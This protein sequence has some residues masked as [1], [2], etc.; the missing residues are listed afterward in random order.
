MKPI[1]RLLVANR[2]EIACRV[3][4]T[5][6][7]L[8]IETVA[9]YADADRHAPHAKMADQ[10]LRIGPSPVTESYLAIDRILDAARQTRSDAIHPGYGLLSENAAFARR[11]DETGIVFVGPSASAIELMG[12]KARAKRA[13]IDAG[14]PCVPG[15]QDEDQ[16]PETLLREARRIGFPLMV[17][18]VAGG[19]GRGMRLVR[20]LAG[21]EAA[22]AS[23]RSEAINAFGAGELILEKAIVRPRHVEVQV[24]GDRHGTVLYLGERDCSV[25]R[26]HQ[27]VIE[28]APCPV[29]T[30]ELRARMGAAA[31]SAARAVRYV[32]AGTVEFLLAEDGS[33]HFL[34]MNTR[35]QVEHPVTEEI[36]GLDLV[37]LQ[38]RVAAGE[39]LGFRQEDVRLTGHAIEVRLYAED[40][41]SGFVPSTGPI[42]AWR[43]PGG[44]GIRVDSGIETGGEVSPFYDSMLAKVIARGNSR[45]DALRRLVRSLSASMLVG[46]ATNRDFLIEALQR[47]SFARGDATTAFVEE[48]FGDEG[49]DPAPTREDLCMAAVAQYRLRTLTA[50]SQSLG[51]N[52]ELLN[53]S[54]N[55]RLEGVSVYL[56]GEDPKTFVV[57][58]EASDRYRVS[59]GDEFETA[60]RVP[61]FDERHATFEGAGGRETIAMHAFGDGRT[62]ALATRSLEFT[63][64][65]VVARDLSGETAGSGTILSPMHG[66]V[67]DVFVKEGDKVSRGQRIAL[68]EAM[69]M[70]H[71]ITADVDGTV[72]AVQVTPKEQ[73]EMNAP[74]VEIEARD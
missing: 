35:L 13:M 38:L 48:E 9:V 71:E 70:Q 72:I 58:P 10:A 37:E 8:G 3:M 21:M 54:S 24:F 32:G 29:M 5:A 12:D 41:R 36:T 74:I 22:I 40:P 61:A 45:E 69:K 49:Y 46:P 56:V 44:P 19:G 43:P 62:L 50:R 64:R 55:V 26:R 1:R 25:Q 11:C 73:I 51:V 6:R 17:K 68:M 27:K 67:L 31:V 42:R 4:R 20:E 15:Y 65:D 60:Y 14:V 39:P 53:W 23:A 57:R 18:A 30:P 63:V 47:D 2:G 66:Q 16:R 34:E 7:S 28:E 52:S 33:F 59:M